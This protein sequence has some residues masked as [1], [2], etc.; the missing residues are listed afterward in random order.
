MR[1]F[2]RTIYI[3]AFA[4]AGSQPDAV[5]IAQE[6]IFF[7]F[8]SLASFDRKSDLKIWLIKTV[9]RAA[10]TF[11][12]IKPIPW[13]PW[14]EDNENFPSD[15][16]Y[17]PRADWN[18]LTQATINWG[19]VQQLV[20]GILEST[21]GQSRE[22]LVL[23]DVLHLSTTEIAGALDLTEETVRRRLSVSRFKLCDAL[24]FKVKMLRISA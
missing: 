10:G 1:P 4:F 7:A 12:Y 24:A 8:E 21:S 6:A 15:C 13:E 5:R 17:R 20:V 9:V 14:M 18:N 23:R 2:E 19:E 3:V 16:A 11:R 22:V